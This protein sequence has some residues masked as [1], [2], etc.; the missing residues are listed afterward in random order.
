MFI[1]NFDRYNDRG[2]EFDYSTAGP[3]L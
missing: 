1:K 2:S 3:K